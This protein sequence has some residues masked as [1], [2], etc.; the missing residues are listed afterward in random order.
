MGAEASYSGGGGRGDGGERSVA[1]EAW[2][3]LVG[4]SMG[5]RRMWLEAGET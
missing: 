1:H 2:A 3:I 5:Q 4:V